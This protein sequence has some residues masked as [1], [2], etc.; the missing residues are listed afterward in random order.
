MS[1]LLRYLV[2][3][4][5]VV[6]V[7]EICSPWFFSKALLA[8]DSGG[9]GARL[10]RDARP[11]A[12]SAGSTRAL[13]CSRAGCTKFAVPVCS[14]VFYL[15]VVRIELGVISSTLPRFRC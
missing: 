15:L 12:S 8:Q 7:I 13:A 11:R 6:L 5:K 3:V 2:S 14:N 10:Q 4:A 1:T 9:E